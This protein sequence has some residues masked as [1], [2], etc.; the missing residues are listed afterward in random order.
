MSKTTD[1]IQQETITGIVPMTSKD[2]QYSGI[3]S[4]QQV[5]LRLQ[6]GVTHKE[7]MLLNI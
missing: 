1:F 7:R 2:R 4:Y 5:V 3:Y 6:L